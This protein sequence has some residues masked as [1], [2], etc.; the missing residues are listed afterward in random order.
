MK[1]MYIS[2]VLTAAM[3][4]AMIPNSVFAG[5]DLTKTPIELQDYYDSVENF[6]KEEIPKYKC[7]TVDDV[8]GDINGGEYVSL[9][10]G[11]G[12]TMDEKGKLHKIDK[13]FSAAV[14]K[15]KAGT[16]SKPAFEE[17]AKSPL[18]VIDGQYI[19][20]RH[21]AAENI[22]KYVVTLKNDPDVLS[23]DLDY[24]IYE[25][26]AN[27]VSIEGFFYDGE[28]LTDEFLAEFPALALKHSDNWSTEAHVYFVVFGGRDSD[29]VDIYRDIVKFKEKVPSIDVCAISTCLAMLKP[30][31]YFCHESVY[32]D[33]LG[34]DANIDGVMDIS[35]SVM[36]MQSIANPDK[37]GLRGEDG[38]TGQGVK[39]AD[40]DGNGITNS[41]ALAI[42]KKLLHLDENAVPVS[43]DT[44]GLSDENVKKVV[45]LPS[46]IE[47]A[48]EFTETDAE[49][50]ITQ[51]RNLTLTPA[52]QDIPDTSS[53]QFTSLKSCD[54]RIVYENNESVTVNL[55]GYDYLKAND[56]TWYKINEEEAKVLE[57]FIGD[58]LNKRYQ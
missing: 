26:T 9:S 32:V 40:S 24:G 5:G 43:T 30:E 1:K 56:G 53:I 50:I 37:Y 8:L 29:P 2:F 36:I 58:L 49:A 21:G 4:A 19:I 16:E 15:I 45:A 55:H 35:D 13:R 33:G 42:Q 44:L 7:L 47:I 10:T 41:D 52:G 17:L 23:I 28:K 12:S 38:I 3:T 31:M 51:L 14:A 34:G 20:I 27:Y 11:L 57:G 46:P 22:D 39:N 48:P 18:V 6:S 54:F 25:D